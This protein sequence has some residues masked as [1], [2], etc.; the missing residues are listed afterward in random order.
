MHAGL[1]WNF[2]RR[3]WCLHLANKNTTTTN[4]DIKACERSVSGEKSRSALQPIS[5]TP[6]PFPLR[7]L[8]ATLRQLH[9]IF[10]S[11]RSD[12]KIQN[13]N[14]ELTLGKLITSHNLTMPV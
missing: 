9:P 12:N 14:P 11:L 3:R 2:D 5:V 7:D 1:L 13:F 6:A 10:G 4:H 8:P